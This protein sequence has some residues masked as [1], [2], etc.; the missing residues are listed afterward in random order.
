MVLVPAVLTAVL[1]LPSAVFAGVAGAFVVVGAWEWAGFLGPSSWLARGGFVASVVAL[2]LVAAA[3]MSTTEAVVAVLLAGTAWWVVAAIWVARAQSGHGVEAS[4][5]PIVTG[6]LTGWL[7]LVPF[8]VGL[9]ALHAQG[10]GW[11]LML[12][13]LIW[14]ADSGAFFVGQRFGRHKLA[15]KVSPGKTWEGVLGGL[16]SCALVAGAIAAAS[17]HGLGSSPLEPGRLVLLCL[18]TGGVSVLGDLTESLMKRR[19]GVKDSGR[20][21]PGHGGMLDRMDSLTAAAPCFALGLG[22]IGLE[23]LP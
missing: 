4:R 20:L 3:V 19:A 9:V 5:V 15:S 8:W 7:T 2:L 1:M 23:N 18:T 11:V 22:M 21:I 10:P 16:V 17:R 14:V 6:W 12:L 13:V